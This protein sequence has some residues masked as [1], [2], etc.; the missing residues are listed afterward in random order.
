[1]AQGALNYEFSAG[2]STYRYRTKEIASVVSLHEKA[3]IWIQLHQRSLE[4]RFV[5]LRVRHHYSSSSSCS[6]LAAA[7]SSLLRWQIQQQSPNSCASLRVI[8][9]PQKPQ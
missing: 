4:L 2:Q 3:R 7:R 9:H 8:S 6:K 5:H 1:L